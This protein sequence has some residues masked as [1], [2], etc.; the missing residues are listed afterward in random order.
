MKYNRI[1]KIAMLVIL[2]AMQGKHS[3]AQTRSYDTTT[4][5]IL[6]EFAIMGSVFSTTPYLSFDANYY[7]KDVDTVTV[8]DTVISKYKINGDNMYLLMLK[9]TIESIQNENFSGAI[10]H[11]NKTV[12]VQKPSLL[13]KQILQIDVM[14]SVFQYMAMSGMTATDS[15]GNRIITINF[16][17]SAI[18]KDFKI[19][20]C[21]SNGRPIYIV[22]TLK[23]DDA[24]A[25]ARLITPTTA[26]Y[27]N[28]YISFTNYQTG[29]FTDSVFSTDPYF[30]VNS[31]TDI[32]L[33]S[34]MDPAYEIINLID[35]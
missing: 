29:L 23:K 6:R 35:Q 20:Y 18:Y 8:K 9:D 7:L 26:K 2:F 22:Y 17:S 15:T 13:S 1:I 21:V 14:D 12:V 30:K 10:Y 31:L 33:A 34:G 28:M 4:A 5:N 3:N 11:S 32:Q 19:A 27:Y 24:S 25:G 16:D